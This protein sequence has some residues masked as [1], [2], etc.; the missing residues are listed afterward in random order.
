MLK[1]S[2]RSFCLPLLLI[3][4]S[5]SSC[6]KLLKPRHDF[7]AYVPAAGPNY[8]L[9][10]CWAALPTRRDSADAVPPNSG[11]RDEQA[12]ANA[13]VF[14]VH[15]T[16]F[17]RPASWNADLAKP[18]LNRFTDRSTIRHQA[19]AF[20][21]A[22]RIYAPRYRQ[23]TLYSFFDEQTPNGQAALDLAYA[24]VKAAFQYY[25]AQYNQGRPIIIAG[26]S[27]GTAHATRL[28]HEF[29]DNDPKLRRQLV[30][31]YLVGFKVKPNEYQTIRPCAD[32]LETGCFITYNAVATSND[33]PPFQPFAVTNP[34]TWKLDTL[35]APAA[36]NRGGVSQDF[37]RIDANVTDAQIHQGLLWITPP[38]PGGYPRFLLPGRPELR[39][40]FHIADYALFYM[41]IRENA[42]TRVRAWQQ[43]HP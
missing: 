15:P 37:K 34:L 3:L 40:S 22:G 8:A 6:I 32:S 26:H 1:S 23:A 10:S 38:K 39:H 5:L 7:V 41:N 21:A 30:A 29:F 28:L 33:F 42:K 35:L 17:Y 19:S 18:R 16:T 43:I 36:L 12:A 20:N 31:A 4:L 25:L 27:Q 13:D 14:F 24:D 2:I 11:L 9:D